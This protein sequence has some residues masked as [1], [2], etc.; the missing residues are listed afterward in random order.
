[1]PA[2]LPPKHVRHL[3]LVLAFKIVAWLLVLAGALAIAVQVNWLLE[4][5]SRQHSVSVAMY[6]TG[7]ASVLVNTVVVS[8]SLDGL[9]RSLLA[10][11]KFA[12]SASLSVL[13]GVLVIETLQVYL[14]HSVTHPDLVH[15]YKGKRRLAKEALYH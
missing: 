5:S 3:F 15:G 1:M 7:W 6:L 12:T 4:Q 13:G 14:F 9:Q 10:T 2:S 11:R 8:L